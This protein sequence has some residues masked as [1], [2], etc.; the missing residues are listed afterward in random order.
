L[1][2]GI[3]I[4]NS[5]MRGLGIIARLDVRLRSGVRDTRHGTRRTSR[6]ALTSIESLEHRNLLAMAGVDVIN[7]AFA[8]NPVTIH[9]GDT[10]D[11]VWDAD[12][13]STTSVAGSA[14]QWDS[15]V[16]NTGFTFE[17][18]FTHIGTFNYYCSIHGVDNK[19]GTASGMSGEI[20]VLPPSPLTMVMVT[21]ANFSLAAGSSEQFMA[22]AMYADNT[23]EDI[24][25][26]ATWSSSNPVVAAV[27]N[28]PG[29]QGL[30]TG[31]APG[32]ATITASLDGMSG[33]T[34]ISITGPPPPVVVTSVVDTPLKRKMVS[35]ITVEFS[36]P[37]NAA[38]AA[39]AAIYRIAL[40]GKKGSFDA[41]NAKILKLKSAT[42]VPAFD[43][44]VLTLK[45]PIALS[46][47]IQVRVDGLSPAGLEDTTGRLID[48]DHDGQPGGNAVAVLTRKGVTLNAM[49]LV[50]L[51]KQSGSTPTG[52]PGASS[53][54]MMPM[55]ALMMP[56]DVTTSNEAAPGSGRIGS[57]NAHKRS[58]IV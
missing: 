24:S 50:A 13:H 36:G 33:S 32:G 42:Y 55:A 15:G 41:K 34:P 6:C 27:S 9:V 19:N 43:E 23:V 8:P 3:I 2:A 30:V 44:V 58:T 26:N 22:M 12:D 46:K 29:S 14:E 5:M 21:P 10:V 31:L 25:A 53:M 20:I 11:W 39:D 40:P 51:S 37:V 54:N 38:Q 57:V 48:G 49:P 47:P 17:H 52:V 1:A 28:A 56:M 7:F 4:G 18:T 16:H 35:T 45:K